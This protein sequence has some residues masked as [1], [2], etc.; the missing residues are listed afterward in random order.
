M[1]SDVS[2]LVLFSRKGHKK[3][4]YKRIYAILQDASRRQNR[5][6]E[7]S[8]STLD[9]L[10]IE[11]K[12]NHLVVTD[13]NSGR[14]LNQFDFVDF[15]WWGRAKQQALAAA[16]YLERGDV[17]FVS[18]TIASTQ[19]D[20]KI[21]EI[22]LMAD[23]DIRLPYTFCSSGAQ[24]LEVFKESP[25][26]DFPL[27]IK[28]ATAC[29]G[30]RN[31]LAQHYEHLVE[32]VANNPGVDFLVQEFIPNDCDYRCLVFDGEIKLIIRRSR[33]V[34]AATHVNNTSSGGAGDLV[35]LDSVSLAARKMV[36]DAANSMGR[37][38]FSGVDLIINKYTGAPYIL[39]VNEPPEIEEGAESESKMAALFDYIESSVRR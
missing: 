7:L 1:S 30:R 34:N 25:P 33:G 12:D 21:G 26:T 31:Y 29:G 24:I 8:L 15:N 2:V 11:V 35:P 18:R 39:E 9:E 23:G 4:A 32:I 37:E 22:A 13:A 17:P 14:E 6:L 27:I 28:D 19:P 38:Q 3:E 36:I 16:T 5:H 10:W 20:S